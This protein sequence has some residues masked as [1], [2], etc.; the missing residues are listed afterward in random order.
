MKLRI[1]PTHPDIL[2]SERAVGKK[3]IKEHC[4]KT[5]LQSKELQKQNVLL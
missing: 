1:R 5:S 2:S 4:L 3:K